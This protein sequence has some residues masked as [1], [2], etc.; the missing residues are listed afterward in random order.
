L[1]N[2]LKKLHKVAQQLKIRHSARNTLEVNDEYDVQDLLHA[3][4]L[5]S[6]D[7]IRSEEW[8]PSYAGSSARMDFL[9]KQEKI[10]LEVK[11]TS[12]KLKDKELGEQLILDIAHYKTHPDC[13]TLFCFV[14]DPHSM[15]TKRTS[16]INDLNKKHDGLDVRI[17]ICP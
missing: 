17:I 5:V 13:K 2:I 7:D 6:F 4:L 1:E 16:I 11:I 14:Y 15:L 3:I 10:V 12:K 8:T 9:L